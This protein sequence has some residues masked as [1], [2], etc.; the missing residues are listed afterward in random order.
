MR[1]EA[2]IEKHRITIEAKER[3]KMAKYKLIEK[4]LEIKR[5]EALNKAQE[6]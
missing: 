2:D 4:K 3:L 1:I 6:K 5:L